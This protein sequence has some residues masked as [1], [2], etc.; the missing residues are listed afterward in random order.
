[1]PEEHDVFLPL[2]EAQRVERVALLAL[3]RRLKGKEEVIG[4]GAVG[5]TGGADTLVPHQ[6][7]LGEGTSDT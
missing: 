1:M 7:I 3:D 6:E 4:I 5:I 2:D